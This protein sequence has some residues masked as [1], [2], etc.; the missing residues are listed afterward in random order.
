MVISRRGIEVMGGL[1]SIQY[2]RYVDHTYLS[3][4]VISMARRRSV[5]HASEVFDS[6]TRCALPHLLPK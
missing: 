1:I 2:D 3:L 5:N 4:R 6:T